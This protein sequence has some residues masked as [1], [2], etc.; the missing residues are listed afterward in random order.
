MENKIVVPKPLTRAEIHANYDRRLKENKEIWIDFSDEPIEKALFLDIDGVLQPFTQHRFEYV[1]DDAVMEELYKKLEAEFGVNYRE[2]DKYDV[3]ATYYDWDK[4]AVGELKRVL[5]IT[6][7]KIVLSS[8]WRT[9][10]MVDYTPFLLRMHD[11]QKYLYGYT[12]EFVVGRHAG[13]KPEY[14]NIRYRAVEILEY[15]RTH[16]HIKNW[17]AVDDEN[18][19]KDLPNHFVMTDSRI[20]AEHADRCIEVLGKA[21]AGK[22]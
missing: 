10:I 13:T 11:L 12:P 14:E 4:N 19:S 17:V 1:Y 20:T 7:A 18:L 2:F 3:A 6:G 15:L 8:N 9:G 21:A 16:P 5:D 22:N